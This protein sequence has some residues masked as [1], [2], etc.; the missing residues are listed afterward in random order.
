MKK[1]MLLTAAGVLLVAIVFWAVRSLHRDEGPI[2]VGIVHSLS[3]TMAIS[4]RH[5]K[6]A[7]LMAIE[8]LNRQG[9]V[10]GR[11]VV[12]VVVDGKS[13]AATFARAAE[14]LISE[15]KVSAIF[16]CWT[17]A[18]RKTMRP[19]IEKYDHLLFYPVQFE[20]LE[21]SPNI[22]YTGAAPNQQILPAVQWCAQHI[23]KRFFLIGS[24]Y[25]FP[26]SANQIIKEAA[27][28]IG[29]EIVGEKY[30][31]LG[32]TNVADAVEEIIK[33]KPDVVFNSING[34]TNREFFR[35]LCDA[36]IT[37]DAIPV[38][39][40]SVAEKE[41]EIIGAKIAEGHYACWSYFQSIDTPENRSF[42]ANYRSEYGEHNTVSDPMEAAYYGVKLWAAAVE[43][44]GSV[45]PRKVLPRLK[46][47][48][49]QAPEGLVTVDE[50]SLYT[51]KSVRIGKIKEDGQ[52]DIVWRSAGRI[53]PQPY[54]G[55]RTAGQWETFLDQLYDGWGGNWANQETP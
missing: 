11:E 39:S 41:L 46:G 1:A 49:Y 51:I 7:T 16:G 21:T 54:V 52:F 15:E 22:V 5:V 20:G 13:D 23:G 35:A 12:P 55:R 44:A 10:L 27:K 9:G 29:A 34:G 45:N 28:N 8:E 26:R 43:A 32:E 30:L 31:L 38:M 6:N 47:L 40:F 53:D 24:D 14:K 36:G 19:V 48:S 33:S 2:K 3:G 37:S 42:V 17:S 25:V 18:S 4:E 50:N